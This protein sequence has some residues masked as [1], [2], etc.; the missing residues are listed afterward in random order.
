VVELTLP[1]PVRRVYAHE[2]LAENRGRV[3]LMRGPVVYCFEGLD[4]PDADL[5]KMALPREAKLNTEHRTG[6]LGG[7]T[8]IQ[9]TGLDENRKPIRLT[10]IPYYAWANRGKTPMNLWLHEAMAK[11]GR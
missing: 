8:L 10:A 2:N 1:M 5:F 11:V 9:A 6:L 4:N 7:V 3:A